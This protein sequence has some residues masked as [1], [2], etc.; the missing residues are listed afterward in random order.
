MPLRRRGDR[1]QKMRSVYTFVS[2][3]EH[4]AVSTRRS[5]A[6]KAYSASAAS[7]T[8]SVTG[9]YNIVSMMLNVDQYPVADARSPS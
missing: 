1:M 2:N 7:W 6:R 5:L 9:W 8:S 4:Q 3:C